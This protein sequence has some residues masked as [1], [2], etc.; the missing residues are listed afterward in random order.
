MGFFRLIGVVPL[1]VGLTLVA[2]LWGQPF[3]GFGSPP[4][5]FRV[6][7]SFVAL[8]FILQGAALLSGTVGGPGQMKRLAQQLRAMQQELKSE[9]GEDPPG[10]GPANVG[11]QCSACGAPLAKDADVSPHGD[12]KCGHCG[13]WFNIHKPLA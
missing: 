8:F 9:L 12:A 13:K 6:F 5:F 3:D 1:G 10:A 7:G 4:M 11:Y 2:F